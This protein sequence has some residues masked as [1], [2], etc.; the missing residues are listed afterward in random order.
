MKETNIQL[1]E[2]NQTTLLK[3]YDLNL[4]SLKYH[5]RTIIIIL[6]TFTM[7][8][9]WSPEDIRTKDPNTGNPPTSP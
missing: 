3:W 9:E 6:S 8:V 1:Y 5:P 2:L 7:Q 4:L